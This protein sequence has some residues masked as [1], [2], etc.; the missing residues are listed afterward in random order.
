AYKASYA[1]GEI[2]HVSTVDLLRD[3]ASQLRQSFGMGAPPIK[4]EGPEEPIWL[5]LDQAVPL[6]LLVSE[7]VTPVL[8]R[9]DASDHPIT[10]QARRSEPGVL[11]IEIESRKI[12]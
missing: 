8:D 7:L 1:T 5:D 3:I 10:I 11:D 9:A 2:G 6:G 4:V 12:V